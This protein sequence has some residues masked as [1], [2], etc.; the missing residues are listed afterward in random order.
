MAPAGVLITGASGLVGSALVPA[1]EA[2][3]ARVSRMGRR[4]GP[5][6]GTLVWNPDA[7]SIPRPALEGF[8]AVVHLAGE[9]IAS[10]RWTQARKARLLGS[11]VGG[12][13][14]LCET[15]AALERP[16]RVLVSAS[17][18]GF[19]G[20]RGGEV[21]D[22]D[23]LP[24]SGFLAGLARAW[25]ES[26]AAADARGIRVVRLRIAPVLAPRGGLLAPLRLPFRLGL[27]GPLGSGRQWMSWIALDDLIAAI[28]HVL[29]RDDLRGAVNAAAPGAVTN[30]EFTRTLARV[31]CRPAIL[32]VPAVVLR[33]VLGEMADEA[34]L[35]S[36][37][38]EP[39]RL[40]ASGF[41]FRDP[42]LEP[43]L[44]HVLT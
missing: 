44:R 12:T 37:R 25:E 20:D 3:G 7:R 11:R 14:L 32:R 10:G 34:L 43:A 17:A 18:T 2:G 6:P 16:P 27:G 21:L 8:D 22:E 24:G 41:T 29:S 42:E 9:S 36:T 33:V 4:A 39:R 5:E 40:V 31:L 19:Y 1:L 38:V 30:R 26:T 23:C 28:R 35:A 13:R 15:L